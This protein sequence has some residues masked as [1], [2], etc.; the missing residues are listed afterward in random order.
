MSYTNYVNN[1]SE[2]ATGSS[3]GKGSDMWKNF[4]IFWK[5]FDAYFNDPNPGSGSVAG[6]ENHL[7]DYPIYGCDENKNVCRTRY[8]VKYGVKQE[9]PNNS[10]FLRSKSLTGEGSS[11]FF[12]KLDI[13]K[14]PI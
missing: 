1:Y 4:N 5:L 10:K 2:K 14:D 12:K 9:I 6:G 8:N 11:S 7:S 13:V 3:G